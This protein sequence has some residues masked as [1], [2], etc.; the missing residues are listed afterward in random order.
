MKKDPRSSSKRQQTKEAKGYAD[1]HLYREREGESSRAR[2]KGERSKKP[3]A[4]VSHSACEKEG[5][6]L[7]VQKERE[8]AM[9]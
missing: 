3:V 2:R 8:R 7:C 5:G 6:G 9:I 1:T 4:S